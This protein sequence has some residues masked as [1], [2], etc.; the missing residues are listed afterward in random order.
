MTTLRRA[1]GDA[2]DLRYVDDLEHVDQPAP[3]EP[4]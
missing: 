1:S 2:G 4:I 3:A